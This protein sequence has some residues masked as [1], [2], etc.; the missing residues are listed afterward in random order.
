MSNIV[1][2]I[3][4]DV[5]KSGGGFAAMKSGVEEVG[6]ATEESNKSIE[7]MDTN[8]QT[9][10][11]KMSSAG[12]KIGAGIGV[13]VGGALTYGFVSSLEFDDAQKKLEASFPAGSE[14][15]KVAGEAAGKLYAQGYAGSM[16][17]IGEATRTVI[18]AGVGMEHATVDQVQHITGEFLSL[19]KVIGVDVG[20][21]VADVATLVKNGLVPDMQT[22][23][24][25]IAASYQKIGPEATGLLSAVAGNAQAFK[26]LG[27][28]GTEAMGLIK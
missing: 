16:E 19:S 22:G 24:D 26:R 15:A 13:A 18:Q 10:G 8:L 2:I 5:L 17:S 23:L 1:E 7:G 6:K 21:A 3:V 25:L 28:D 11:E 20:G 9:V 12:K 4:S 27:I 14:M